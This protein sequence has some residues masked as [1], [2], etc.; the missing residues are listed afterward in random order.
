MTEEMLAGTL[1]GTQES[2]HWNVVHHAFS[3]NPH[4]S[5]EW[6]SAF[7]IDFIEDLKF[8]CIINV[9]GM[10]YISILLTRQ[11]ELSQG[12]Q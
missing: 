2:T 3:N 10:Y 12:G 9:I 6:I 7:C 1:I 5:Y 11:K 8:F 4:F